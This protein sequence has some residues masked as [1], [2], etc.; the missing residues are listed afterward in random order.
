MTP[1]T[2]AEQ[3]RAALRLQRAGQL[4]QARALHEQVLAQAPRHAP[5]CN[6]LGL[7]ELA[8]GRAERALQLLNVAIGQR[9]DSAIYRNNHG[10]ALKALG[11]LDEAAA[12]YR[13]ALEL[14]PA[15]HNARINLGVLEQARGNSA[16]ALEH[17]EAVTRAQP[18]LA[19]AWLALAGLLAS[20]AGPGP[21]EAC[22]RRGLQVV[23]N[24]ATLLVELGR[25]LR[26]QQRLEEAAA[27]LA[28]ALVLRPEQA[29]SHSD[30]GLLQQALGQVGPALT[31]FERALALDPGLGVAHFNRAMLLF[32]MHRYEEAAQGFER[33]M[34][35]DPALATEAA[36]HL[37]VVRRHLCD[38][39]DEAA[40]TAQL[41]NRIETLV[42][43]EPLR[44]LPPL[45]L[46]VVDVP[47]PLRLAVARHLGRGVARAAAATP[48]FKPAAAARGA[49]ERL[50]IGYVS[51]DFRLHAVGSLIHDLFRHHDRSRVEVYAYALI[52]VDD[53]YAR[54]VRAGV[55]HFVDVSRSTPPATAQRIRDDRIDV[56]V[57]MAGYTAWSQTTIFALRPAPVQM[58]WLG[59]LDTMGADFLPYLLA[60]E[61]VVPES[62]T[63]HYSETVVLL[64]RG[65]AV[66][67]P[68]TIGDTPSRAALGLPEE[69]FVFCCM[70]GLHKIEAG[71]FEAWMHILGRVPHSVLWLND[72]GSAVA[73]AH[74]AREAAQCGIDPARLHY[75]QRAPM[76]EY[77]ARY[78]A[79]DL[80]LDTFAYNA[81]A[82]AA[83][84]LRAGLPVLTRPGQGFMGR[85]GASLCRAAGLGQLVCADT[86][87]YEALAVEL[88]QDRA[89]WAGLRAQLET[90]AG[91]VA[92][93][94]P[95]AALPPLFDLPGFARQLEAAYRAAWQ[96]SAEGSTAR[97]IRVEDSA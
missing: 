94:A 72:E 42:R 41:I 14:E 25:L 43:D 59:Y 6:G 82:T 7:I 96:H 9:P 1:E 40:H 95:G 63:D 2:L 80:F 70:N 73:R 32:D 83:G 74:L 17:L 79:A 10:N 35:L 60:D 33:T 19:P 11:H 61:T 52:N 12:A 4:E 84:A 23:P 65:F 3:T 55:D 64:P 86:A 90:A 29:T 18:G 38:W 78:R 31:C 67:S 39:R 47:A 45:T 53:A 50:R 87:Q 62:A 68:V 48:G 13:Q 58:H 51:A 56:L 89:A 44:G 21:A 88:A 22:L 37:A 54:S 69:A 92:G 97:R 91:H 15:Y 66:A 8:A 46:N 49:P 5:A 93:S 30:L 16:A 77:L 34:A 85:M 27:C 57:D 36:C 26:Q 20:T 76:P 71:V 75:A 24:D 81:G 28:Q